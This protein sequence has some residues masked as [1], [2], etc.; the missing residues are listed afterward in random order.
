MNSIRVD[1]YLSC[2]IK[3]FCTQMLYVM[4]DKY[5][6]EKY[7]NRLT[8]LPHTTTKAEGIPNRICARRIQSQ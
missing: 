2:M 3:Y 5:N 1:V 4:V 7:S 8:S 6:R